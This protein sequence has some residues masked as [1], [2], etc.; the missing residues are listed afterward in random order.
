M[1]RSL[2]QSAKG[3][4]STRRDATQRA[5]TAP[6]KPRALET[7]YQRHFCR[8]SGLK[9]RDLAA[10]GGICEMN[11][12]FWNGEFTI[13]LDPGEEIMDVKRKVADETR[14]P[15]RSLKLVHEGVTLDNEKKVQD[16]TIP[17][18]ATIRAIVRQVFLP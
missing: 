1:S 12:S 7:T 8:Y 9:C 2:S 11:V 13:E 18:G 3:A 17:S 4:K 10:T 16:Y 6:G 14:I 5:D 15:P